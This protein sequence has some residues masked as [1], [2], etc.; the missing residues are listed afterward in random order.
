MFIIMS[1]TWCRAAHESNISI[2]AACIW[3]HPPCI[4]VNKCVTFV[5]F[6]DDIFQYMQ[7]ALCYTPAEYTHA[8][9]ILE[10]FLTLWWINKINR[11]M[12]MRKKR[13]IKDIYNDSTFYNNVFNHVKWNAKFIRACARAYK[14]I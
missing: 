13:C 14:V 6:Y 5:Y 1:H 12:M 11:M 7:K 9:L 8:M 4:Y 3:V 10:I 2:K